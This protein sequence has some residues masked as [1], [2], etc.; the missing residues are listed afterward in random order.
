MSG[1]TTVDARPWSFEEVQIKA[2]SQPKLVESSP[3]GVEVFTNLAPWQTAAAKRLAE[4]KSL[5]PNWDSYGGHAPTEAALL[6]S[7]DFVFK[8]PSFA[9]IPAP[10]ILPLGSGGIQF[11]WDRNQRELEV[12]FQEDGKIFYLKT[13]AEHVQ[14]S[15]PLPG[16]RVNNI[17][18]LLSWLISA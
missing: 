18:E 10:R 16:N 14:D 4:F 13:E 1:G 8:V 2:N 11:E 9:D 15:Q 17:A 6:A 5:A 7:E 12:H 3:Q